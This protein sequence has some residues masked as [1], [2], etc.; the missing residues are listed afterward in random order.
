MDPDP[1]RALF[2]STSCAAPST[3]P[4]PSRPRPSRSGRAAHRS[5]STTTQGMERLAGALEAGARPRRDAPH[6]PLAFEPEPG[7]FIDT[8]DRFAQLDERIDHP[9]FQLT[10]DLGHVHCS[11]EGDIGRLLAAVA[12]ADRQRPHR[13]HG[14]RSSRASDVR[15]RHDG[16]SRRSAGRCARSAIQRGVHVELSRHSH[17][18]VAAVRAAKSFLA[19]LLVLDSDVSHSSG[20][21]RGNGPVSVQINLADR[22]QV[23]F[24][25]DRTRRLISNCRRKMGAE[26]VRWVHTA[27][28]FG[29]PSCIGTNI[30]WMWARSQHSP[31]NGRLRTN[32]DVTVGKL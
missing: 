27:A 9:L 19:P 7:M 1:A 12:D 10:V 16:L 15:R 13:G 18:A 5:R 3:W 23:R 22:R 28:T 21:L 25:V 6:M 2:D 11:D 29:P 31:R 14:A 30:A 8:L 4:E 32:H 17:M 24:R 26:G 20:R